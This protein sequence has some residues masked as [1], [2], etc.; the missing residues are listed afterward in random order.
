M[1][2]MTIE[3]EEFLQERLGGIGGSDV[4]A[5]FG[6]GWG[7][8]KKLWLQKRSVTPDYPSEETGPMKLGTF[9][10]P[11]AA[12]EYVARTG[13]AAVIEPLRR[14]PIADWAIVHTDRVLYDETRGGLEN[15]G[16]LEIKCLGR[17]MFAKTK[18]EGL[19]E[20]YVLQ[21]QHGMGVTGRTWGAFCVMSRDNGDLL[22]WD[23]EF[24][25]NI[26][27]EIVDQGGMFWAQVEN[28]PM[29]EALE[30]DDKRCQRCEYRRSCQGAALIQISGTEIDRD[31]ALLPLLAEY[32]E[33]K[34]L[35]TEAESL[36]DET[37][38]MLR[39]MMGDRGAVE[40]AGD[41]KVYYR[42]QTRMLWDSKSL[43]AKHPELAAE[44]KKASVSR[45]LRIY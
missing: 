36:L 3:R 17:A 25:P 27:R 14:H 39:T 42:P 44:F 26:W 31:D 7:C 35:F 6:I 10:E 38:E 23:V 30:P 18:R 32:D 1:G 24:D 5:V 41:R 45:P 8:T 19:P 20:D 2:T 34:A 22:H 9:L 4:A 40:C 13:R 15:P 28:G 33:R 29:P 11:L 43:D 21:L 16:V 12:G 37:K